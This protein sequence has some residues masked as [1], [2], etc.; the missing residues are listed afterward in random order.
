MPIKINKIDFSGFD[1][2]FK[3]FEPKL[4]DIYLSSYSSFLF[5]KNDSFHFTLKSM[6]DSNSCRIRVIAICERVKYESVNNFFS[7]IKNVTF[8]H[9]LSSSEPEENFI[10]IAIDKKTLFFFN[11][12]YDTSKNEFSCTL[13]RVIFDEFACIFNS[14]FDSMW[15]TMEKNTLLEKHNLFQQDFID[16]ASHQLRNPI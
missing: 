4:I 5:L 14:M 7:S 12:F 13:Y 9:I 3:T 10:T 2:L 6:V 1:V 16:M 11:T 8:D 15:N